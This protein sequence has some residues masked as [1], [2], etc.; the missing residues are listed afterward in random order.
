MKNQKISRKMWLFIVIAFVAGLAVGAG[1]ACWHYRHMNG[2]SC[3]PVSYYD[4]D[5][6]TLLY[7]DNSCTQ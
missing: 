3:G 4:K 1:T 2:T 6:R 5:G 7:R